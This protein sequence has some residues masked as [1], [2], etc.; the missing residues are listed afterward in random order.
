MVSYSIN[1]WMNVKNAVNHNLAMKQWEALKATIEQAGAA[2][3]V[4]EPNARKFQGAD[5]F[6]DIVFTANAAVI[7]KRKAYL[8]NFYYPERQGE[9]LFYEK[10]LSDHGYETVGD[11]EIPFEGA[12]DA[13]WGG[14]DKNVLF[15]GV[16]PRTDV[17][18]LDDVAEKLDDGSR[19]KVLGCRLV[20]PRFYHI[21][22][23]FCPLDDELA[24]FFPYAFDAIS[25]HNIANETELIPLS[26]QDATLFACNAV[27]VGKT[28]VMHK[29]SSDTVKRLGKHGFD[30]MFTDMSEFLKSGGSAKCCTLEL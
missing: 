12:G 22:T 10:W 2:T 17:R 11:R 14:R 13:L 29:C 8:A 4:L 6:P 21:D 3:E 30:V 24:M 18:A 26:E 23:C 20:D 25:R 27:V 15:I 16:G 1:P 5:R 7:R 28:V 19:F 9:R